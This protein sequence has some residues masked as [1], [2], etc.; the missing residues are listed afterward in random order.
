MTRHESRVPRDCDDALSDIVPIECDGYDVYS[1]SPGK[2]GENVP[3]T[4]VHL[5]VRAKL[6]DTMTIGLALRFKTARAIDEMID[7]L[8]HHRADVWPT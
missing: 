8:K 5:F 2:A 4:Q 7:V 1:W 3:A 6:D